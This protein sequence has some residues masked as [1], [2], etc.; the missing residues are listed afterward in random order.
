MTRD[1]ASAPRRRIIG[2]Q[3]LLVTGCVT[4][5]HW[6][7]SSSPSPL[8]IPLSGA[9]AGKWVKLELVTFPTRPRDSS[10]SSDDRVSVE[11]D[12]SDQLGGDNLIS[13]LKFVGKTWNGGTMI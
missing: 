10:D 1:T 5:E 8:S 13:I 6:R 11:P 7:C 4:Y 3:P 2:L 12:H 9:T